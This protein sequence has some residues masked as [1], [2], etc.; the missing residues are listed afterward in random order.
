MQKIILLIEPSNYP[1]EEPVKLGNLF[2]NRFSIDEEDSSEVLN[3]FELDENL[4]IYASSEEEQEQK[5]MDPI[6]KILH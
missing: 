4:D 6:I 2:M 1:C 5:G 3:I